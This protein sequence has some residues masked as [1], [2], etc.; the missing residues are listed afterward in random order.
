MG[1]GFRGSG[2]GECCFSNVRL[3]LH[4]KVDTKEDEERQGKGFE[5]KDAGKIGKW[6]N[7]TAVKE[8]D[9]YLQIAFHATAIW[10]RLSGQIYLEVGDFEWV[11]WRL[12]ELCERVQKGELRLSDDVNGISVMRSSYS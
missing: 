2:I 7:I 6:I 5:A 9:T 11:G 8:F 1:A 10:V 4:F 12:K 3:P